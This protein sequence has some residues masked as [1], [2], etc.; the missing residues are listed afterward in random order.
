MTSIELAHYLQ[1]KQK[2]MITAQKN[3][4]LSQ[5]SST[6]EQIKDNKDSL[7]ESYSCEELILT[8]TLTLNFI[9]IEAVSAW[10]YDHFE[11]MDNV[12]VKSILSG[13]AYERGEEKVLTEIKLNIYL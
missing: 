5:F 2:K 12:V 10:A 11:E 8:I 6:L 13:V 7:M 9:I 3:E 1:K 4:I